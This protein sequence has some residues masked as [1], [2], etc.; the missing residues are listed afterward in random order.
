MLHL[1]MDPRLPPP[2]S[3]TAYQPNF[4]LKEVN[5]RYNQCLI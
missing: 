2:G 3:A 5:Y 1:G 4:I